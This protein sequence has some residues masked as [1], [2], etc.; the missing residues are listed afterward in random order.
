MERIAIDY[1]HKLNKDQ[2]GKEHILVVIDCFTRYV[3]LYPTSA[4]TADMVHQSRYYK[5]MDLIL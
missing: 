4:R 5:I 2:N 1:I 3:K